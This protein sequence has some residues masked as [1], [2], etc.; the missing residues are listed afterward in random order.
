M[1]MA[2]KTENKSNDTDKENL[3]FIAHLFEKNNKVH[4]Q[5]NP[6]EIYYN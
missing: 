6:K 2:M 4:H 1:M 5:N 3:N